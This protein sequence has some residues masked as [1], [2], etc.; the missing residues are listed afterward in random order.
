MLRDQ[1]FSHLLPTIFVGPE[2]FEGGAKSLYPIS[3]EVFTTIQQDLLSQGF[4]NFAY[5]GL[6]SS[7]DV[8]N[9]LAQWGFPRVGS[10]NLVLNFSA[11]PVILDELGFIV[12]SSEMIYSPAVTK[13]LSKFMPSVKFVN[14]SGE[15]VRRALIEMARKYPSFSLK[16]FREIYNG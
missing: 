16:Q 15:L 6:E 7:L 1:N 12:R 4:A 10:V 2:F 5:M 13:L 8:Y 3:T 14:G 11:N 9:L